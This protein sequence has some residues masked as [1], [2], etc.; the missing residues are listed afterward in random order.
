MSKHIKIAIYSGEIPSTTFIERLITGLANKG[1]Y[2]YVFGPKKHQTSK[3]NNV[4]EVSYKA[5]KWSKAF[6]FL[7]YSTLLFLFKQKQKGKLDA[8]IKQ[9]YGNKLNSKVKF[10]PVLWHQPDI[11]HLQWAKGL[12][13][14]IWVKDFNIKLVLSLR[15]AHINYSPIADKKLAM[16]YRENFP[17][18]NSF[19][20]VSKAIAEESLQYAAKMENIKVIYSGLNLDQFKT[21]TK[22][23]SDKMKIL[24]IGRPHWKK[25]YTY[26]LDAFK[27][28][29]DKNVDFQYTIVGGA[30]DIELVYQVHDLNLQDHVV[31]LNQMSLQE[32]KNRINA[33]D[34]LLLPSVEEGIANVALEAMALKTL[35]LT[36]D[37]GGM[38]EAITDGESGFVVPIRNSKKMAEK[39]LSINALSQEEL[40]KIKE[41]AYQK[42]NEQH[43]ES[44]M[45][46]QMI[47]L[48]NNL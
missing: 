20:A 6:H 26:A 18:V 38:N 12:S 7:K 27:I 35:V 13:D 40:T 43:R 30:S 31:L 3:I 24:S 48:Y 45:V 10:Y 39:I 41:N 23:A 29:K 28:L 2:I 44:T 37:C 36:T 46:D 33:S 17:K 15:G 19:H 34:V 4:K 21:E 14:W 22:T 11:F 32:V 1:K 16:M 42:I 25:G 5:N 47:E 9:K 8:I